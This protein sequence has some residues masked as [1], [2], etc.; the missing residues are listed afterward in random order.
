[1]KE[2]DLQ[3][4]RMLQCAVS[5]LQSAVLAMATDAEGNTPT[6]VDEALTASA[7]CLEK[8]VHE[9]FKNTSRPSQIRTQV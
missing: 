4:I 7:N 3:T 1:M 9:Y 8:S 2:Q 5:Y 6:E